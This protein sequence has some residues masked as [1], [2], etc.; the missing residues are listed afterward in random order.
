MNQR[1]KLMNNVEQIDILHADDDQLVKI[2]KDNLLALN[3]EEMKQIKKYFYKIGRNPTDIELETIAQT[4]SEHCK[5][6]TLTGIIEYKE[7]R[8]KKDSYSQ[9]LRKMKNKVYNNLLKETIF[10]VTKELGKK[11]CISVFKDN[12]G[13]IEFDNNIAIAFKVETHNHP[14]ALEPYGGAGTGIGGVIRDILGVGLGAKPILNTDVFCFGPINYRY[15]DLPEGVLHPKR[16]FKGVVAGVRDYGNRMG[17]P[18]ANGAVLFDENYIC[19]PLVYCGTVGI[20]PK[21]KCFKKVSPGDVII[22]VGGRTG[23]DGIHG[24]TFSS[25]ELNKDTPLSPVQ[26]G[27]PIIEKKVTDT[28]LQARDKNLY[29]AITDCGAGGFSSAIGELG[30]ECGARVFLERAPLKYA[31]LK[32]WEIWVSEA[33]ERMILAVPRNNVKKI[34]DIFKKEDVEATI[35][36]EFTDTDKLEV[37]YEKEKILELDNEFLHHGLPRNKRKAIWKPQKHKEPDLSIYYDNNLSSLLKK[38]LSCPNVASKEWIIRQYDYEVQGQTII[39]PFIG[40]KNDGPS[41]ACVIYP[42]THTRNSYRGFVI[43]CGI[44]PDYSKIDTYWMAASAIDEALR[45]IVSV[46]GDLNRTALLDNFCWGNCNKPDQL[47]GIVRAA[48]A[49]YDMAKKYR[50]PFISGKDSLNNEFKDENGNTISVLPTLLISAISIITDIRKVVT[51]DV[52][53]PGNLLYILGKTKNELGG[54]QLYKLENYIGNKVPTVN[55]EKSRILMLKLNEAINL[56]L[57]ESCHDCSDGGLGVALA[58]MSFSGGY[59]LEVYLNKVLTDHDVSN[60]YADIVILF[61]ETNSRFIVEVEPENR[62]EFERLFKNREYSLIGKVRNDE[63]FVIYGINNKII[64]EDSI[65]ELKKS[66]QSAFKEI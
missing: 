8:N 42:Y 24:A 36:G 11:W 29:S 55:P 53:R 26:I 31:G 1:Q 65:L 16:I 63:N 58:E 27:N 10:R 52:K 22:A 62:L 13:I 21:T 47:S 19:N 20:I 44:N 35:L 46:G 12:A 48:Q 17:I 56:G 32:P 49:C 5:H 38:V 18:T 14:S 50:V 34:L 3:L 45:N 59:G 7:I 57:I 2:S 43:G 51:A 66:W 23:R 30:S 64:V 4:W 37:Y 15:D 60:K 61:S 39:K 6:K 54:S 28:V 41:D 25:L 9:N 33:Q 40:K